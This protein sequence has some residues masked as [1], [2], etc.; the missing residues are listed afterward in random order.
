MTQPI[1]VHDPLC[2]ACKAFQSACV[3]HTYLLQAF[4]HVCNG[5]LAV[6]LVHAWV[7]QAWWL[8]AW[9]ARSWWACC[10]SSS[11]AA[12]GERP[13]QQ[14]PATCPPISR[15]RPPLL[16]ACLVWF[17]TQLYRQQCSHLKRAQHLQSQHLVYCYSHAAAAMALLAALHAC[18][19]ACMR[20]IRM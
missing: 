6:M 18:K 5:K 7:L 4:T 2:A 16:Q 1:V 3:L 9:W 8:R 15:V 17:C 12:A 11:R 19:H 13:P 10:C 14:R 20:V